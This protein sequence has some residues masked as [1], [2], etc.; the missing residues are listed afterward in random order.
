MESSKAGDAYMKTSYPKEGNWST[1]LYDCLDDRSNCV[2]TFFCPCI[3]MGQIIE[4]ID[5]GTTPSQIGCGIYTALH[6]VH[7]TWLYTSN[8]RSKLRALFNLQEAPCAD[9]VVHC[10][11]CV[12]GICQE[13]RELKNRGVDPSIGWEG[14]VEKWKSE[15]IT[16]PP[17]F[18]ANITR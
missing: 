16:V 13:Y 18:P 2:K 12:C 6:M 14:N 4:I 17:L 1:G 9:F 15:G 3:T 11:C 7:C 5:R 8:Y 10:C